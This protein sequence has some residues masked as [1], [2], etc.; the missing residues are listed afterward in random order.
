MERIHNILKPQPTIQKINN[1]FLQNNDAAD[2]NAVGN[3]DSGEGVK[4]LLPCIAKRQK[5]IKII[6]MSNIVE[7]YVRKK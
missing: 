1:D 5:E 6:F 4:N 7:E 3:S 2:E